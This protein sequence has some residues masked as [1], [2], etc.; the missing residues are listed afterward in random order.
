MKGTPAKTQD[1]IGVAS[2][3]LASVALASVVQLSTASGRFTIWNI[4]MA[5][6]LLSILAVFS[7]KHALNQI[8]KTALASVWGVTAS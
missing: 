7:S 6:P 3:A 8:Q 1:L 4:M 5:I 2:V